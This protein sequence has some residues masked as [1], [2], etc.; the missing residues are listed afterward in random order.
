MKF[1]KKH[2]NYLPSKLLIEKSLFR[3]SAEF[4]SLLSTWIDRWRGGDDCMARL[5][6]GLCWAA[7]W[8]AGALGC[9]RSGGPPARF[10][11]IPR[12][13]CGSHPRPRSD[14]QQER[15]QP[16][17]VAESGERRSPSAL[18]LLSPL[19]HCRHWVLECADTCR[20][21][22]IGFSTRQEQGQIGAL[23]GPE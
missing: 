2:N 6:R 23:S 18:L 8:A 13:R 16:W 9:R 11:R 7:P 19:A 15:G 5:P 14:E 20:R 21:H 10:Y 3:T 4:Q 12:L 22:Q 1:E 17:T